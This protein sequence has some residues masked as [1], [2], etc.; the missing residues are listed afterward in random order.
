[1][2]FSKGFSIWPSEGGS[3]Y[4]WMCAPYVPPCRVAMYFLSL[5]GC[6]PGPY[7]SCLLTAHSPLKL[8]SNTFLFLVPTLSLA[9]WV[10]FLSHVTAGSRPSM[11][12]LMSPSP[13]LLRR[14]STPH[15]KPCILLDCWWTNKKWL[16]NHNSQM[17][18]MFWSLDKLPEFLFSNFYL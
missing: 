17:H 14:V 9:R 6:H 5:A 2:D 7:G 1:M 15:G 12:S 18:G 13:N 11:L 10:L 3:G 8:A 16:S 4:I